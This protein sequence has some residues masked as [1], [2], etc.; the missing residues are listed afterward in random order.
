MTR[1]RKISK[2]PERDAAIVQRY[3]EDG[4]TLDS[5]S[6]EFGISK[7]RAWVILRSCGVDTSRRRYKAVSE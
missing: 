5:L 2:K 6:A 4:A 1:W 7:V 3:S